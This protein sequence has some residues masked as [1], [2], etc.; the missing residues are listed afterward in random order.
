MVNEPLPH[1]LTVGQLKELLRDV[2]DG[3][4]VG[5][6]L[7]PPIADWPYPRLVSVSGVHSYSGGPICELLIDVESPE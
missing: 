7:P 4:V 1:Q 3:A 5:V 6:R 2:H